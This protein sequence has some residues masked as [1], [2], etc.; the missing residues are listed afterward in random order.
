MMSLLKQTQNQEI[1]KKAVFLNLRSSINNSR[2][3]I[4]KN[5]D[6]S[7][8]DKEALEKGISQLSLVSEIM[9]SETNPIILNKIL[10]D[11]YA[12]ESIQKMRDSVKVIFYMFYKIGARQIIGFNQSP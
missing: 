11:T 10:G 2:A 7:Y 9:K 4:E 3:L 12:R 8:N 6:L 5:R 1:M